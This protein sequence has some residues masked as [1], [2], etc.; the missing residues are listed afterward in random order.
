MNIKTVKKYA[1]LSHRKYREKWGLFLA[2][3]NHIVEELLKSDW[4]IESILISGSEPFKKPN[5][6][7]KAVNYEPVNQD[8]INKIATTKTPQEILAVAKIPKN[9]HYDFSTASRV[10]ITDGIKDPGNM[11]TII[12][13]ARA[14]DF[15]LVMTTENSVDIFNPKVVRASQGAMFGIKL[16]AGLPAARIA[17][18]LKPG[19]LI[20]ALTPDGDT[21]IDDLSSGMNSALIIG[22]EIEGVSRTLLDTC[23]HL[24]IIPHSRDVE[25]LNA[26]VAAG[27]AM[28]V[29]NSRS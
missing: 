24:I 25:S 28:F 18:L 23:Y 10:I 5:F 12:R 6:L 8:V 11:G 20:C 17:E 7:K 14:F 26:A 15:D 27:I 22:T 29:F 9:P 3:G 13:T 21:D 16:L 2:E 4:E 1:S 19:H